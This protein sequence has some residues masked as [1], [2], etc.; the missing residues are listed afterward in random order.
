MKKG[1]IK[2]L[3]IKKG[4]NGGREENQERQRIVREEI[5]EPILFPLPRD[6][7]ALVWET[8]ILARGVKPSPHGSVVAFFFSK[9]EMHSS[10]DGA[11]WSSLLGKC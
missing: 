6:P 5:W 4:R 3:K 9:K 11:S 10:L 2:M 7:E 1:I 8:L